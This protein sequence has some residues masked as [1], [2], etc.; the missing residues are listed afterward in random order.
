[1]RFLKALKPPQF[2]SSLPPLVSLCPLVCQP[3]SENSPIP[4][5]AIILPAILHQLRRL[6]FVGKAFLFSS[7]FVAMSY[8]EDSEYDAI[9]EYQFPGS[10]CFYRLFYYA[11]CN[12]GFP[13]PL[14]FPLCLNSCLTRF[15][16]LFSLAPVVREDAC[17]GTIGVS[18][19]LVRLIRT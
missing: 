4:V 5:F 15:M 13:D 18:Q 17:L 14:D 12:L 16:C 10:Y 2:P 11:H 6:F 7:I 19:K 9:E 1:M 8:I 3:P